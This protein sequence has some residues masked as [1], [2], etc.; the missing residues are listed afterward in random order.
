MRRV[1]GNPP[2]LAALVALAALTGPA[3]L[4]CSTGGPASESPPAATIDGETIRVAD[5]DAFIKDE[6]FDR[7]SRGGQPSRVYDLRSDALQR[8]LARRAVESE[9]RRRGVTPEELIH[10]EVEARGEVTDE[11]VA[12]FYAKHE[13]RL[14]GATLEQVGPRIREH[15]EDERGR[16][17]VRA[18][19]GR[20]NVEVLLEPPR[21]D[22]AADGPARGPAD[23]AVTIVE[24]SD[25]QCPYCRSAAPVLDEL[26]ARH[27]DDVRLVYRH[28]PL[29]RIH[30]R[31]RASALASEC[32]REQGAFWKYHDLLFENAPALG[33]ADLRGYAQKAG[34]DLARFDE[35]VGSGRHAEKVNADAAAAEKIGI[36][37]T[38]AFVVNGILL[39]GLQPLDAIDEVVRGEIER[40]AAPQS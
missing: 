21:V 14:R 12:A 26:L 7:E 3:G 30:P 1:A 31:A 16:E 22:V 29:D 2:L 10:S 28:L 32:A 17:V 18:L 5:V 34:L 23:A 8:L 13:D 24:F 33:D 9:A 39:F 37:G 25:F 11:E 4:G 40:K 15:L 20:A 6:L 27:P 35:C 38:P 36:T 19:V